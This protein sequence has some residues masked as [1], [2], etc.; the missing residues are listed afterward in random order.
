M[1]R[2]LERHHSGEDTHC[3]YFEKPDDF[4]WREAEHIHLALPGFDAGATRDKSLVRHL[5]I[6]TLPEEGRVG[7]VTRLGSGSRYKEALGKM[8]IGD[9]AT[10][11]KPGNLLALRRDG[12]SVALLAMGV[13]ADV[14]RPLALQMR[15]DATGVPSLTALI[16]ARGVW[17]FKDEMETLHLPGFTLRTVPG[18]PAFEEALDA[19]NLPKDTL[20][21]TVGSDAF[22]GSTVRCLL[23]KGVA[24]SDIVIDLKEVKRT[25]LLTRLGIIT[26]A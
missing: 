17:P 1:V 22:I 20:Y 18:R 7:L 10:L 15:K 24:L 8:Q 25:E 26:G 23:Q 9:T 19:L 14:L 5:S 2:L 3:F 21:L 11:F 6:V 13:A 12:R 4:T 16:S